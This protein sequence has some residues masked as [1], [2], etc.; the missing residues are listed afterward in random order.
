MAASEFLIQTPP[1]KNIKPP[2]ECSILNKPPLGCYKES[3]ISV[4]ILKKRVVYAFFIATS[5]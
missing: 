5:M 1:E 4:S 2:F 3:I